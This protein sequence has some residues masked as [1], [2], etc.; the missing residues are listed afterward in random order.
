MIFS[1]WASDRVR[2]REHRW[3]E[4]EPPRH[5]GALDHLRERPPSIRLHR[6]ERLVVVLPVS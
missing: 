4:R 5:L 1:W 3:H 2:D 6:V